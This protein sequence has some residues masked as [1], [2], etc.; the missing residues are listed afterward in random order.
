MPALPQVVGIPVQLP[1][2][3]E[4]YTRDRRWNAE[5]DPS[6]RRGIQ[7][8]TAQPAYQT[9]Q[10]QGPQAAP[11]LRAPRRRLRRAQASW[12]IKVADLLAQQWCV[13]APLRIPPVQ[14]L[15]YGAPQEGILLQPRGD[16]RNGNPQYRSRSKA[17]GAEL[18]EL[19]RTNRRLPQDDATHGGSRLR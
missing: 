16:T 3:P 14:E 5:A 1:S 12:N 11:L 4:K 9:I 7:V 10:T 2:P 6:H 8:P 15:H 13:G 18:D 19:V 17:W